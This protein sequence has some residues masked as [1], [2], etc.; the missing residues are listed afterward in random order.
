M[1]IHPDRIRYTRIFQ[2][3]HPS[4]ASTNAK[5]QWRGSAES[6]GTITPFAVKIF[7]TSSDTKVSSKQGSINTR[8]DTNRRHY[9]K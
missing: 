5:E 4:A 1:Y 8:Y 3:T 2:K 7:D 6:S 9:H